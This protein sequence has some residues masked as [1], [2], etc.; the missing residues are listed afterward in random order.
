MDPLPRVSRVAG[1]FRRYARHA[2]R[3][4]LRRF[5]EAPRVASVS[6][7]DGGSQG[8]HADVRLRGVVC[9]V[10]AARTESALRSVPGVEAASVDLARSLA[11]LRLSPG[12]Q[13]NEGE[14]QRALERV[15]VGLGARRRLERWVS[16]VRGRDASWQ[17]TR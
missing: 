3:P 1:A 15:V 11:T 2:S 17:P 4:R 8:A 16:R 5:A 13:V 10:C 6:V 12:A 9:G 14:L 7:R